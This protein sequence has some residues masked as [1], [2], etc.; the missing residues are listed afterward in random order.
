MSCSLPCLQGLSTP[1]IRENGGPTATYLIYYSTSSRPVLS[2]KRRR[3]ND[4]P[5]FPSIHIR[6]VY[7]SSPAVIYHVGYF[8][9]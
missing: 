1:Q 6:R 2:S 9:L 5:P 8:R 3:E 7:G 4:A